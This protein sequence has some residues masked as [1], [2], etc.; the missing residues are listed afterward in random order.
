MNFMVGS[1]YI[2][3]DILQTYSF[4][5]TLDSSK[6]PYINAFSATSL[7]FDLITERA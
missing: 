2:S 6:A 4:F 3:I 5:P 1:V 7:A